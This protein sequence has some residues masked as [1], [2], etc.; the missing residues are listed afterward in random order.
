MTITMYPT[1]QA[2]YEENREGRLHSPEAGYGTNWRLDGYHHPWKVSYVEHTGEI[3]AVQKCLTSHEEAPHATS[4]GPLFV[5]GT[6]PPDPVPDIRSVYYA[7]LDRILDG[8]TDHCGPK[9]G[10]TW[11]RDCIEADTAAR[12]RETSP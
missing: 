5:L 12:L 10:L 8:W 6:V 4:Y 1:L 9:N 7:T 11:I 3:Y 2:F